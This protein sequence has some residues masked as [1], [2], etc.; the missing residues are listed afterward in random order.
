MSQSS[1]T[2]H[3]P[4]IGRTAADRAAREAVGLL[5]TL[6]LTR[7]S[8]TS[9]PDCVLAALDAYI[10]PYTPDD[11]AAAIVRAVLAEHAGRLR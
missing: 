2:V 1:L 11:E 9:V 3:V 6:V 8:A 4:Y 5:A 7:A 10:S